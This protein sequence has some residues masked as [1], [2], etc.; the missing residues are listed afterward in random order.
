[1]LIILYPQFIII[2][3]PLLTIRD[4]IPMKFTHLHTHSHYS[5]LD[6]LPKIDEL[7]D[8]AEELGMDSVG[9]T[10]HGVMYGAIE[11]YQKAKAR[12][13]KPIIGM[14]A[15]LAY[16][17][18]NQKRAGIDNK[19]YHLILLAKNN[20]GYRNLIKLTSAAHLKGLYYKPRIDKE[21]LR[22]YSRG[23]IATSACIAGEIPRAIISKDLAKAEKLVREYQEIF[24]R[25][26]FYLELQHHPNLKG[27]AE[28]NEG[29][30][31]LAKKLNAPLT[32]ANDSHYLNK[33]DAEAQD[34]LMCIQ[35]NK[36][37]N[38]SDRLSMLGE[39]YSFR[40][41][42]QMIRDFQDVPEAIANTQRIVEQCNVEIDLGKTLLP[43]FEVPNGYTAESYL[44]KLCY[45]GLKKR[46]PGA[47]TEAIKR[48][49]YELKI[50][51]QTGFASY[52][53]IVQDFVN[54][55]K[56][57][58][59]VVGPGRGSAAGSIVS[60][61]LK[62][63]DVDP[64]KYNLLFERFLNPERISMPDIDLDF[65][66][67][68]RDEVIKYVAEKYGQDH[69]AQIITFG[70]MAARAAIRDVGR[71]LGYPYTFCD[72]T[73]KTIP[74]FTTLKEALENV[75]EVKNLYR[76]DPSAK[77]LIDYSL[78]LEGVV[79]HASTHACGVVIS[80]DK[81]DHYAPCQ[82]P[83]QD[84]SAVVTQYGMHAIEDLGLLKMDFLGLKNLTILEDT[85]N[86]IKKTKNVK[87]ELDK[88]PLDNSKTLKLFQQGKTT[89]VFQFESSGM[90]RYL[91]QLKP[92]DF[93][94]IIAMVAMYRPGP[95]NSGMVDEFINRKHGKKKIVYKH[96]IMENALKNTY[97]VI[98]YQ[99][100]VMQLSKDMAG[101]TGGQAD[102]LRKAIGK[103]IATLMAKVKKEFIAGCLK[104][105]LSR[106]LAEETSSDM[107]KFAE[108]G[109][110]RSH[111]VCY[112]L[113]GYQ[114]AY[115]KSHY[116][117]EFMA[118]LL[119]SDQNNID[120]VAI[121]VEECRQMNIE[122]LPPNINESFANFTVVNIPQDNNKSREAIRFGLSAIKN[123][124]DN[125]IK[126]IVKARKEGDGKFKSIEN[127][128]D[129]VQ[130]KDL[131]KK[132]MESLIRCGAMDDLGERNSLLGNLDQILSYAKEKQ[133][134]KNNGQSSL[135]G[136]LRDAPAFSL[137]LKKIN[138][139]S[140]KEKLSWEKE[141]LGLYVSD[142][143]LKE[144]ADY[145]N[146]N[147]VNSA[148]FSEE[149]RN[150][151]ITVGGIITK[152][153]NVVTRTGGKMLF[154]TLEDLTGKVEILV[155][156][157]I[158]EQNSE[159][160]QEEKVVLVSGK[161]SDKDGVY[162]I[163]ADGVKEINLEIAKQATVKKSASN[164]SPRKYRTGQEGNNF[165]ESPPTPPSKEGENSPPLAKGGVR[166][167]RNQ[168]NPKIDIAIPPSANSK[169]LLQKLS[170]LLKSIP[171]GNCEVYLSIPL[172]DGSYQKIKTSKNI[173]CDERVVGKIGDVVEERNVK[174]IS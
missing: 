69:V 16:G 8:K 113:I 45:E 4:S 6:G 13:I 88:I 107:E 140:R 105:N 28:S 81:I 103:K 170:D 60:Y 72:Q 77:K 98:I 76:S 116:P 80:K 102:T 51:K 147:S 5:L 46:Y 56:N 71:A 32:A 160:W 120:R 138:P 141:L 145:L 58:Q 25:E 131:N 15:Y 18:M 36:T 121:E 165:Q 142:H 82:H 159:I 53:L 150:Q 151:R 52:F 34:I 133:K 20:E 14:E 41:Q 114:T 161:L 99:E 92:T 157:K 143:P 42:E 153:Q 31:K 127:F 67:H 19:R 2:H 112:A 50:I 110:N 167:V 158:L 124:G 168:N 148:N 134:N 109:F 37:V 96:P 86:I 9:L 59:I 164:P 73:A 117:T 84:T 132:S 162:K 35:M 166:G 12:N 43:Y 70:T 85:L 171:E 63:T 66:D 122:V 108:Y 54:W 128:I 149:R 169:A 49:E 173:S 130:D 29:M 93:E 75:D 83:P 144:Y 126:V 106:K 104:N 26:N 48:L 136:M 154:A 97:G 119:T 68:R 17:S 129:R 21:I 78:K 30:I 33:E 11:F 101:F 74:M 40:S 79:R 90:K 27:Q 115:L 62:I 47:A 100:Q 89:G 65:A 44:E 61:L 125:I 38:D 146:S 22:K 10:D 23:L 135:F 118:A 123:V 172:P 137:K 94:D 3:Y 55:A 152:I 91:K 1:M 163:L 95:L 24:G 64:L 111:A 57:K 156:P 155:F 39:D 174:L 7:L 87:I 139:A